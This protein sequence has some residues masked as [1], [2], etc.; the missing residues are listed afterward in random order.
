MGASGFKDLLMT[1][2]VRR[3]A[4][5]RLEGTGVSRPVR[6][7]ST[8]QLPLQLESKLIGEKRPFKMWV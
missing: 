5:Q 7:L 3:R 8:H 4:G 6:G 2:G 1:E